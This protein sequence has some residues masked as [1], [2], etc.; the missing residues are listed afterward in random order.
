VSDPTAGDEPAHLPARD[1]PAIDI[2]P[3]IEIVLARLEQRFEQRIEHLHAPM[4]VPS[5]EEAGAL[6]DRA[7]E[8]Y[9]LWLAL[10]EKRAD[11]ESYMQRAA[12]D[13]PLI[14]AKRGQWFALA[15]LCGVLVLCAI[16]ASQGTGGKYVA[17]ALA[18]LDLAAIIGTFMASR[19]G[20]DGS[21]R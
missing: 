12:Y 3:Q 13:H 5:A 19:D 17:G 11:D 21:D 10:T 4:P 20:R 6:R 8:L 15:T 16:L 18:A 9:D 14:L 2:P 1:E 7:P